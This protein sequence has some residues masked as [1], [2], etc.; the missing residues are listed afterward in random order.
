M[1]RFKPI[2]CE[3]IERV[4][5][6]IKELFRRDRMR[7]SSMK[8]FKN[9]IRNLIKDESGQGATEYILLLV[10]VVAIAMLFKDQLMT[11]VRDKMGSISSAIS[12]FNPQ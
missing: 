6:V 5:N 1:I 9:T 3:I 8:N 7:G 10:V 12:G 4:Y 11:V 2:Q